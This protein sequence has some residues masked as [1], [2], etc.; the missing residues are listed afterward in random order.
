MPPRKEPKEPPIIYPANKRKPPPFKPLRPSK[1]I[2]TSGTGNDSQST[3]QSAAGLSTAAPPPPPSPP[4]SRR[5]VSG[6]A[7]AK[8][9]SQDKSGSGSMSM[10][11]SKSKKP[12]PFIIDDSDDDDEDDID[13]DIDEDE[14]EEI[15][16]SGGIGGIGEIR[17]DGRSGEIGLDGGK[18][19]DDEN[20]SGKDVDGDV[21]LASRGVQSNLRAVQAKVGAVQPNGEKS[22][23]VAAHEPLLTIQSKGKQKAKPTTAIADILSSPTLSDI[24]FDHNHDHD[25]NHEH[26]IPQPEPRDQ[27]PLSQQNEI[28]RPSQPLILRLLHEAFANKSTTIDKHAIEVLQKYLEVFVREAIARSAQ[29]KEAKVERGEAKWDDR[30]WLEV[31]DLESVVAGLVLDF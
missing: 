27:Y 20:K 25:L 4:L 7:L 10:S 18:N 13:D 12:G 1:F 21:S 17:L 15:R 26:T 19:D 29:A 16:R 2:R 30:A 5:V 3:I 28:P 31:E 24:D 9:K 6:P 23:Q 14:F 11:K 8:S 22:A